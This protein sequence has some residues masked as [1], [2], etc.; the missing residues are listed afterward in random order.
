[1]VP[2]LWKTVWRFPPKLKIELP[3]DLAIPTSGYIA[4]GN[5]NRISKTYLHAHVHCS[6][7][8]SSQDME[9]T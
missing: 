8:H 1:M 3:Y 4:K 9:T 7:T 6:I 5:E 2:Q